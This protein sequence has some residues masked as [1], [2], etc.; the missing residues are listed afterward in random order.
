M[1]QI[2]SYYEKLGDPPLLV[3]GVASILRLA[4]IVF[5]SLC[6]IIAIFRYER[7]LVVE[8]T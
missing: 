3:N 5:G 6:V 4:L 1:M 2:V 8:H 7:W